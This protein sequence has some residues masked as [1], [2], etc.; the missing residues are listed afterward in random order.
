MDKDFTKAHSLPHYPMHTP[1]T[2]FA[3]DGCPAGTLIHYTVA[4]V[5]IGGHRSKVLFYF[6]ETKPRLKIILGSGW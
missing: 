4:Y 5:N 2:I 6:M 1:D 3:I